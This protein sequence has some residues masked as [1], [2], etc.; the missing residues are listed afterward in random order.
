MFFFCVL[1]FVVADAVEALDEHHHGRHA[2]ARD[3]GGVVQRAA[4][5]AMRFAAG[6]ADGFVAER[7]EFV[8]ERARVDLPE[9]FPLTFT[10]PSLRE[11]FAGV[12]GFLKHL[13]ERRAVEMPLVE[14]DAAFLDDAGNDAGLGCAGADGANAAIAALG[15][16]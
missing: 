14:R 9:A 16:P 2:G 1:D 4:R 15:D 3:F 12:F 7:D 13:G 6:F 5:Q 8:V 11:L 10:L